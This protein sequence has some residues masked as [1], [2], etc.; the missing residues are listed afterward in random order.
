MFDI[1]GKRNWFFAFSL[2][3][4]IPGVIAILLGPITGGRA[5]LQFAIDFTGGTVWSI[6]FQDENVTPQQVQDV[7]AQHREGQLIDL[8]Q[9]TGRVMGQLVRQGDHAHASPLPGRRIAPVTIL[10][11]SFSPASAPASASPS[12]TLGA[13]I[14]AVSKHHS[15]VILVCPE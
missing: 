9:P 15:D 10:L 12:R 5:G 11:R 1:V 7:L 6:R 4:T 8:V 13:A 2:L 14:A 3:L